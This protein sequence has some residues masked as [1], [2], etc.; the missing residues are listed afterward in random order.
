M[1]PKVAQEITQN[2]NHPKI[3][4]TLNLYLNE[5]IETLR[6]ELESTKDDRRVHELQGAISALRVVYK[7]RDY[8]LAV[9]DQG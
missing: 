7:I 3:I 4:N 9:K 8:A 2:L 1:T 6:L 5:R